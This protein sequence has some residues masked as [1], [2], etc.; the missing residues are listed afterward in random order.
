MYDQEGAPKASRGAMSPEL[1]EYVQGVM[2][3]RAR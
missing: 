3:A 1:S 2:A